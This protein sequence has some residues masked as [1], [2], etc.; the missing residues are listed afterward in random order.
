MNQFMVQVQEL[1][2]QVNS[3]NDARHFFDPETASS[4]GLS[5]VPSQPMGI[6]SPRGLVSRGSLLQPAAR[7]TLGTSGH[8]FEDLPAPVEPSAAIF[9]SSRNMA[10]AS[11]EPV[12][13][14][15]G[16]LAETSK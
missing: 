10:S 4:S 8:V 14:N 9:G 7:N 5:H 3:L 6:P 16:R 12:S 11:C 15:T 13:A 1:Q 2:D